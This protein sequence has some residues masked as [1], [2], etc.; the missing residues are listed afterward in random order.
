MQREANKNVNKE[1]PV[2][3]RKG[4]ENIQKKQ[5]KTEACP[6]ARNAE[7]AIIRA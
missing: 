5:G 7:A 1:K 3:N 4:K 6:Y 2:Q